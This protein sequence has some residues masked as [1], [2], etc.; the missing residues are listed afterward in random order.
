MDKASQVY[1]KIKNVPTSQAIDALSREWFDRVPPAGIRKE[2]A[3]VVFFKHAGALDPVMDEMC[4]D[5]WTKDQH[6]RPEV[7]RTIH[8]VIGQYIPKDSIK[9]IVILG[10]ITSLQ[11]GSDEEDRATADIDVNVVLDPPSLVEK[12]WEVRRQYNEQVVPGTRHPVNIYLQ[13]HTGVIPG[14]QDSYFGVYD[15][16]AKRWLVTPPP[17]SSYRDPQDEYW[18]E[19]VSLRMHAKEFMRKVNAYERSKSD[20][21]R[22]KSSENYDPWKELKLKHRILRDQKELIQF[23]EDLQLGRDTVY[24]VGWGTPR[25]GYLNLLFKFMHGTLSKK[26]TDVLSEIENIIHKSKYQNASISRSS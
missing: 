16:L 5:V 15:V 24:N 8:K 7:V 12:L 14:Y 1:K 23:A 26:Y 10:A 6:P 3:E 19:L 20:L 25:T 4:P 2:K 22:F 11:Y 21:E 17:R 13:A 18:A 9:Q